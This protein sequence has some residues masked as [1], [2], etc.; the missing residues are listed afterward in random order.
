[1]RPLLYRGSLATTQDRYNHWPGFAK[2]G[3]GQG[4]DRQTSSSELGMVDDKEVDTAAV[5]N[6]YQHLGI[7]PKDPW[8]QH[9]RMIREAGEARIVA[10]IQRSR[11]S[12]L[13]HRGSMFYEHGQRDDDDIE[14]AS[15]CGPS[16]KRESASE[17]IDMG[18]I[19]KCVH[20]EIS[21]SALREKGSDQVRQST[22]STDISL[23]P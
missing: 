21:T 7:S 19:E 13:L 10:A 20:I 1:M 15:A 2:S 11:Q 14:R 16:S 23:G 12:Q 6:A 4:S 5:V 17:D 9:I 8:H 22:T 3:N 18:T